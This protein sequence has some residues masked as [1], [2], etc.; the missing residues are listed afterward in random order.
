MHERLAQLIAARGVSLR[1]LSRRTGVH[2]NHLRELLEGKRALAS[3]SL[4]KL[5]A[6][7]AELGYPRLP[8]FVLGYPV[9]AYGAL[10]E[11]LA[12]G[13]T[14]LPSRCAYLP[15][16]PGDFVPA[17][18]FLAQITP[19]TQQDGDPL[20]PG[21]AL[22]G[23]VRGGWGPVVWIDDTGGVRLRPA[24]TLRD[25]PTRTA[26]PLVQVLAWYPPGGLKLHDL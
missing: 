2:R 20:P 14:P 10:E 25:P 11:D 23:P 22:F 21:F 13:V 1:E 26:A 3:L 19:R 12:W 4:E 8:L 24:G 7:F 18:L 6:L 5:H 17:A 9:P 15:L 16:P